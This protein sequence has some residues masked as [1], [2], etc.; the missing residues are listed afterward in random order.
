[1]HI[2]T[3]RSLAADTVGTLQALFRFLEV[4]D[5]FVPPNLGSRLNEK[6]AKRLRV[7]NPTKVLGRAPKY[8]S[9]SRLVPGPVKR[10]YRWAISRKVEHDELVGISPESLEYLGSLMVPDLQR[11]LDA[12]GVSFDEWISSGVG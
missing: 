9:I 6:V 2:V 1:M 10:F 12:T 4:D 11:L 3:T 5:S 8:T 7:V